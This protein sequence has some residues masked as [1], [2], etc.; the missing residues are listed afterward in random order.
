MDQI[1]DDILN[2]I[3]LH[4]PFDD[5]VLI[6]TKVCLKWKRIIKIKYMDSVENEMGYFIKISVNYDDIQKN[7]ELKRYDYDPDAFYRYYWRPV[8]EHPL[9]QQLVVRQQWDWYAYIKLKILLREGIL[10]DRKWPIYSRSEIICLWSII[11]SEFNTEHTWNIVP[12]LTHPD[13][14]RYICEDLK[15]KIQVPTWYRLKYQ[16]WFTK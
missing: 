2:I 15:I 3:L 6:L 8:T 14:I 4:I 9:Y 11:K 12:T 1:Y 13:N 16:E 10:E 7:T 5:R